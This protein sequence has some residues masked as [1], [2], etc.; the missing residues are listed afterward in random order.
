[1]IRLGSKWLTVLIVV[2]L[3]GG[4]GL[5]SALGWWATENRKVPSRYTEGEA[6]GEY[7]PADLRGSYTLGEVS[8]LFGVPLPILAEAFELPATTDAAS[9]QLKSLESLYPDASV[10][11][12]VESVRLFVAWYKGLPYEAQAD[13]YLP[14]SAVRILQSR[15]LSS[16]QQ[17]YLA[18]HSLGTPASTQVAETQQSTPL[19]QATSEGTHTP[20]DRTIT[21]K[22]TFQQV[23][24]WGVSQAQIEQVLGKEMPAPTTVI[25]DYA[26]QQGQE[27]STLKTALQALIDQVQP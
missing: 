5:S 16:A 20:S 23:L 13:T 25:K 7:N 10:E 24:D 8:D 17:E 3:F 22:T 9:Y 14:A 26:T 6:A 15:P 12:G 2:I 4:V 11:I 18:S 27:F 1:M 21:G 19:A